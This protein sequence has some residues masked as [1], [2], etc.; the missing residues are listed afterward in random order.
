MEVNYLLALSNPDLHKMLHLFFRYK[1]KLLNNL[2]PLGCTAC[3]IPAHKQMIDI[4]MS[5][6]YPTGGLNLSDMVL[7][8]AY[9]A[10]VD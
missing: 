10:I 7:N 8:L 5:H 9:Q 2:Y 4:F 6:L 1:R 3:E